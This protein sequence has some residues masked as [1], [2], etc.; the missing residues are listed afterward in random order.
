MDISRTF[1]EFVTAQMEPFQ[2]PL[3]PFEGVSAGGPRG[4]GKYKVIFFLRSTPPLRAFRSLIHA[5]KRHLAPAGRILLIGE[6][7]A[8]GTIRSLPTL[9]ACASTRS[10][11]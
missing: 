9:G 1:C 7:I 6:P 3:T 8:L 2:V 10:P 11:S 4:A 5:V